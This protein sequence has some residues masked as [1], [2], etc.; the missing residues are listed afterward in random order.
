MLFECANQ[1][2]IFLYILL[3][4]L[5]LTLLNIPLKI[6]KTKLTKPWLI[7]ID[8]CCSFIITILFYVICILFCYG[9]IRLYA[10]SSSKDD[11]EEIQKKINEESEKIKQNKDEL[12]DQIDKA[13]N[14][15]E[16]S[17]T[18]NSREKSIK[19]IKDLIEQLKEKAKQAK[20][21]GAS[22]AEIKNINTSVAELVE[23]ITKFS[24]KK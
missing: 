21:N 11:F 19:K 20:A 23:A 18:E 10:I 5:I 13:L 7:I 14:K 12:Q 22:K 24:N 4:C 16:K 17:N 6:L 2:F 3:F 9:Q 1:G 8:F 15:M